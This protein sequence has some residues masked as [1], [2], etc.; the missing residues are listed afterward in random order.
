MKPIGPKPP[1]QEH[2]TESLACFEGLG[3]ATCWDDS[4]MKACEL[5]NYH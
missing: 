2:K 4:S 1:T 5:R 3:S